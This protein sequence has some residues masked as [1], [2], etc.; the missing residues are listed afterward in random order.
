MVVLK[1]TWRLSHRPV[2][3][4]AQPM[5]A[6]A[7]AAAAACGTQPMAAQLRGSGYCWLQY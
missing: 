7:A 1:T 2:V 4:H 5:S 6:A 3:R